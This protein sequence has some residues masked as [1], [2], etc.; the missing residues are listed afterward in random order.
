[1]GTKT[2][3]GT[4][5]TDDTIK[6]I[7]RTWDEKAKPRFEKF[8]HVLDAL[9]GIPPHYLSKLTWDCSGWNSTFRFLRPDSVESIIGCLRKA[10]TMKKYGDATVDEIWTDN[11]KPFLDNWEKL[12]TKMV[13]YYG[14]KDIVQPAREKFHLL[15]FSSAIYRE[16]DIRRGTMPLSERLEL[17]IQNRIVELDK[18]QY[19]HDFENFIEAFARLPKT[20]HK[21]SS[22]KTGAALLKEIAESAKEA[23]HHSKYVATKF[24]KVSAD[25]KEASE[26]EARE[27]FISKHPEFQA[28]QLREA[29]LFVQSHHIEIIEGKT[30]IKYRTDPDKQLTIKELCRKVWKTH[31]EWMDAAAYAK[32]ICGYKNLKAFAQVCTD[33]RNVL[34]GVVHK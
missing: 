27:A 21:V 18:E 19:Q 34:F 29:F 23:A 20:P 9:E 26:A 7:A 30:A 10:K 24:Y 14:D 1:M 5:S 8:F 3:A 32:E 13:S 33:H 2:Y 25:T 17:K 15:R 12:F 11:L 31:P 6:W 16:E 28:K 4:F 22:S